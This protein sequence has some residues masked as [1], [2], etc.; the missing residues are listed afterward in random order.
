MVDDQKTGSALRNFSC[1]A[2]GCRCSYLAIYCSATPSNR[3]T[4]PSDWVRP[5]AR[6]KLPLIRLNLASQPGQRYL[7]GT[8]RGAESVRVLWRIRSDKPT[9]G[10]DGSSS[11]TAVGVWISRTYVTQKLSY[12]VIDRCQHQHRALCA[13]E[14]VL[15][16]RQ[17]VSRFT[18]SDLAEIHRTERRGA[19]SRQDQ[20]GAREDARG[21]G[22]LAIFFVGFFVQSNRVWQTLLDVK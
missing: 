4:A 20:A 12:W 21:Q 22:E 10:F 2:E 9:R 15:W 11:A 14:S 8:I 17:T 1:S 6:E 19:E 18:F 3:R 7:S 16:Q 5:P 13:S